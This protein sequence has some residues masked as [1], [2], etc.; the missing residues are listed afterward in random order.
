MAHSGWR[1]PS[2]GETA[3]A[4]AEDGDRKKQQSREDGGNAVSFAVTDLLKAMIRNH[5][6]CGGKRTDEEGW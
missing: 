2:R 1:A 6:G 3:Q 5:G 4:N